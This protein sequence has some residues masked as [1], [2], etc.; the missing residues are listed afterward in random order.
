M[1]ELTGA[2][3]ARVLHGRNV[4]SADAG[5]R[6]VSVSGARAGS[7]L[8]RAAPRR[9][10]GASR[11]RSA[12]TWKSC[13]I[14]MI[15]MQSESERAEPERF[16]LM[17]RK[18]LLDQTD[19]DFDAAARGTYAELTN[20][21]RLQRGEAPVDV[22]RLAEGMTANRIIEDILMG[23]CHIHGLAHLL[24]EGQLTVMKGEGE[25]AFLERLYADH[26]PRIGHALRAGVSRAPL[27]QA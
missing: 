14:R 24:L 27:D 2:E 15:R 23:W 7:A 18:D 19:P 25:E 5:A 10:R 21:I 8:S 3:A 6:V 22:A 11:Q 17:F 9:S 12:M 26:A 13:F 1:G 16:R 20:V 4:L